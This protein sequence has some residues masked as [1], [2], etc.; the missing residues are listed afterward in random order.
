MPLFANFLRRKF[1]SGQPIREIGP[2]H[3]HK[4]GTP[5]MGGALIIIITVLVSLIFN[6]WRDYHFQL[7]MGGF[8]A[9]GTLGMVD[10]MLK[11]TQK[12]VKGINGYVRFM[13]QS[14]LAL[15][16]VYLLWK[17]GGDA[18]RNG[19]LFIPYIKGLFTLKI[20]ILLLLIKVL[21]IVA[22]T[23]SA[24]LADGLDG[25]I[26]YQ[27]ILA[28]LFLFILSFI[29]QKMPEMSSID[30]HILTEIRIL[31][32]ILTGSFLGF[33]WYNCYPAYIFLGDSGSLAIGALIAIMAVIMHAEIA[34][35]IGGLVLVA[36]SLSVILQVYYFKFTGGKRIFKMAP[37]HH[38]FE[39][40]GLH[41][42]KVTV[43]FFI[44]SLICYLL[45]IFLYQ[46]AIK[47]I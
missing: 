41:E 40:G 8:V 37:I 23:N 18:Y 33:L 47:I 7:M 32:C 42:N 5:T 9:F 13:T 25:L 38:H 20:G 1:S 29:I 44:V 24:N 27:S 17:N 3:N 35:I 45:A 26:T 43:R 46:F 15:L 6:S 22:T 2:A 34:L 39:K 12:N 28:G 4:K 30:P 16:I 36:E 14:V 11:L 31:S 19:Y 21:A 10:D